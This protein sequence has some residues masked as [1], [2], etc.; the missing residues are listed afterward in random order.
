M[1]SDTP[2]KRTSTVEV[3]NVSKHGIWLLVDEEEHFLAFEQFPWFREATVEQ[4]YD[5]ER[6]SSDHLYWPALDVD[7]SVDSIRE[8]ERYPRVSRAAQPGGEADAA[9]RRG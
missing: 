8:P 5:V 1:K 2:G 4:I 7:L 6:P 9:K 3:T